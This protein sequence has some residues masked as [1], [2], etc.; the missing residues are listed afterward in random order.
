[1]AAPLETPPLGRAFFL[2]YDKQDTNF[3]IVG[4]I[5][6]PNAGN[7]TIPP[8]LG[9]PC[10]DPKYT[11]THV[12]TE[13][14]VQQPDF[15]VLEVYQILPG[16][17][18]YEKK[19]DRETNTVTEVETQEVVKGT[20]VPG[21]T[22]SGNVVTMVEEKNLNDA[23]SVKITTK[24][25]VPDGTSAGGQLDP[26]PAVHSLQVDGDAR[27]AISETTIQVVEPD[28][29]PE[30][31]G[32]KVLESSVQAIDQFTSK[33][34]YKALADG[35]EWPVLETRKLGE[36]GVI[37]A[38][39]MSGVKLIETDEV[40][41]PSEE[42]DPTS[43]SDLES[44]VKQISAT[45]ANKKG[46]VK[47]GDYPELLGKQT[48]TWGVERIEESVQED[49]SIDSGFGVKSSSNNPANEHAGIRQSVVYDTPESSNIIATL[50]EQSTDPATKTVV[51]TIKQLVD[52]ADALDLAED[53][54]DDGYFTEVQPYDKWH[55]I[56]ISSKVTS[57]PETEV[58]YH[59]KGYDFP[60]FLDTIG[61]DWSVSKGH[62]EEAMVPDDWSVTQPRQYSVHGQ[63]N[64]STGANVYIKVLNGYRGP[65]VARRTRTFSITQPEDEPSIHKIIPVTGTVVIKSADV[66]RSLT[67]RYDAVG[68]SFR[69]GAQVHTVTLGP[70]CHS[71]SVT[72]V[73]SDPVD[74]DPDYFS[75]DVA[76]STGSLP[77]GG[78]YPAISFTL[79]AYGSA[80]LYL[81]DSTNP[82]ESGEW[83]TVAD[84]VERWKF[85]M[86]VREV[87]EI[88]VP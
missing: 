74:D 12:L 88:K 50:H 61:I 30:P 26:F 52:A 63:A 9:D 29:E 57:P 53:M 5:R 38:K 85:N 6:H 48:G 31:D 59:M 41:D 77:W 8:D 84:D 46:I 51:D 71:G 75:E 58:T 81:P 14:K 18:T 22:I 86:W 20:V 39:F 60:D 70:I 13:Y 44:S 45:K 72:L 34:T 62:S 17:L 33:K 49:D 54:R 65:V 68:A 40:V 3:P 21:Q 27:G 7:G 43:F 37:P 10:P 11:A 28:T 32:F 16:P 47:D 35:E 19:V 42:P 24:I 80:T 2:E 73:N 1:M 69:A 82:P 4:I 66:D 55:S 23:K 78:S 83:M 56:L 87:V 25:T 79:S 67:K 36:S 76:V 15:R 64:V